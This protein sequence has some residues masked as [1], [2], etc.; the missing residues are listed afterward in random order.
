[1]VE[2][3]EIVQSP[4]F[5]RSILAI[6]LIAVNAAIAGSFTVFRDISF[7]VAG[8]SHAAL[9]GAA[10]AIVIGVY[11]LFTGFDPLYGAMI[12]AIL[13]SI[14]AGYASRKGDKEQINTTIGIA[15]AMS[16]SLAVLFISMIRE[17]ASQ[18]WGLLLGDILLLTEGDIV[19]LSVFTVIIILLTILFYRE[20]I[21]ISFDM[22]GAVAY[23]IRAEFYNYMMLV[24][25]AVSV[26]VILKGVGAILVFAMLVAPAAAANKIATRVSQVIVWA[27]VIA[28]SSGFIG[29]V[30]SFYIAL[31]AG[32][33]AAL[34]ATCSYFIVFLIKR[35]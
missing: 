31:S 14:A 22:E 2:F 26:V 15:F 16:M 1:M 35:D 7:L 29:L 9:A 33:L 13:T 3:V 12:F 17:Y 8:T 19:L 21:F 11:G 5:I 28:L 30:I 24:L 27:F 34:I 32:A 6:F 4:Y 20:F 23:G 10:F 18:A 25:I